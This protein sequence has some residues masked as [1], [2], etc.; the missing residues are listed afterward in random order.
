M[1]FREKRLRFMSKGAFTVA[2]C[3]IMLLCSVAGAAM[4]GCTGREKNTVYEAGNGPLIEPGPSETVTDAD[5][6]TVTVPSGGGTQSSVEVADKTNASSDSDSSDG[7]VSPGGT[8][9]SGES[10]G[11]G[12][13]VSDGTVIPIPTLP[14]V[15]GGI[16]L[17]NLPTRP[18]GT[19]IPTRPGG[20]IIPNRPSASNGENTN[21]STEGYTKAPDGTNDSQIVNTEDKTGSGS[22]SVTV[23]NSTSGNETGNNNNNGNSN[24]NSNTGTGT[25][26]G[27]GNTGT[28]TAPAETAKPTSSGSSPVSGTTTIQSAPSAGFANIVVFV[29]TESTSSANYFADKTDEI[30]KRWNTGERSLTSFLKKASNGKFTVNNIFPQYDSA[31]NIYVTYTVPDSCVSGSHSNDATL[32]SA[33]IKQLSVDSSVRLDCT[34]DGIIDNLTIVVHDDNYKS[35]SSN[36][37]LWPHKGVHSGNEKINGKYIRN[38]NILNTEI[39]TSIINGYGVISHEFMHSLGYPDLYKSNGSNVPVGMWDIMASSSDFMSYPLAYLRNKISGWT[40]VS[41]VTKTSERLTLSAQDSSSGT[42][43]YILKNPSM[44][45]SEFFVVEYRRLGS[46]FDGQFTLDS[47]IPCYYAQT[48]RNGGIIVYRVNTNIDGLSNKG[49]KNAVY[50]FRPGVTNELSCG[51]DLTNST[52]SSE[53]GRTSFGTS[54]LNAGIADKALTYSNGI[55]SGIVIKNVGSA[56]GSTISFDVEF[57]DSSEGW[58]EEVEGAANAAYAPEVS[59]TIDPSGRVSV[60]NA[61]SSARTGLYVSTANGRTW[62]K[63]KPLSGSVVSAK[64][65]V[66]NRKQ[67]ILYTDSSYNLY[68]AAFSNGII[69]ERQTVAL[70]VQDYAVTAG[71]DGVYIAY[72]DSQLNSKLT[73]EKYNGSMSVLLSRESIGN[74]GTLSAAFAGSSLYVAYR[75]W[76]D[77]NAIKVLRVSDKKYMNTAGIRGGCFSMTADSGNLYLAV[78]TESDSGYMQVYKCAAGTTSFTKLGSNICQ[79]NIREMDIAAKGSS[80]FVVCV[81]QT[82]QKTEVYSFNGSSWSR[83]GSPL[84]GSNILDSEIELSGGKVIV[85]Y[86]ANGGVYIRSKTY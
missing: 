38:Y 61:D 46:G 70:S 86:I 23:P 81:N 55:N 78:G 40:N 13:S 69:S 15:P 39:F 12:S 65:V 1:N 21:G 84:E 75:A 35:S 25:P 28:T 18:N 17:P 27:G 52:L 10:S 71:S 60:V 59:L 24:S 76:S 41:T 44:S 73:V 33:V 56:S 9:S 34:G 74:A 47:R 77:G 66:W 11:E 43:A 64:T 58:Y 85:A 83:F 3:M 30:N 36:E 79:G 82:T 63:T 7:T 4:S 48:G 37:L 67:Y 72:T 62:I 31:K 8:V 80:I 16:P 54:D 19:V 6:N 68:I 32:L 26:S 49:N 29:Q 45:E 42:H 53:S 22:V 5:G 57:P 51:S 50:V 2:I 20:M 14:S